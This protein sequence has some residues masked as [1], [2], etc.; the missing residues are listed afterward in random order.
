MID[1]TNPAEIGGVCL[2]CAGGQKAMG[3]LARAVEK[4]LRF[5]G[6]DR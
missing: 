6:M 2:V 1:K 5:S 4:V 3:I